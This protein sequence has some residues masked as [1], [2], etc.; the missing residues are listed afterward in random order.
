MPNSGGIA[1]TV[2]GSWWKNFAH[3]VD[4]EIQGIGRALD[5]LGFDLDCPPLVDQSPSVDTRFDTLVDLIDRLLRTG[6]EFR[7]DERLIVFTE[8]KTTLD[9]LARRLR[10]RYPA[11]RVLTLFGAGG[12]EGMNELDR[13]NVKAA[14]NSPVT[15]IRTY[16]SSRTWSTKRARFGKTSVPS[17][18][19]S[20][21]PS[22]AAWSKG[23]TCAMSRPTWTKGSP[24][25]REA[26][27][28]MPTTPPF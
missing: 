15:P 10:Q 19:C 11:E 6:E 17:T 28:S 18:K 13:E 24:L 5:A 14:F 26:R 16:G 9:Y 20:T 25:R 3:E 12:P 2:A 1:A 7:D 23:K 4:T 22:I 8:Y 21:A 27:R